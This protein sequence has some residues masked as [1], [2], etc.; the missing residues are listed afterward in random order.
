VASLMDVMWIMVIFIIVIGGLT[1]GLFTPTEAGSV[2]T[3]AILLLSIAK[4]DIDLKRFITSIAESM[5]TACMVL[6]LIT[7]STIMGHFL[8]V[9]EIP[10]LAA[11]WI[12]QLPYPPFLIMIMILLIYEIGGS[13]ID[14]LAFMILAT[15][16]FLPVVVK[17]GYDLIWFGG[18]YSYFL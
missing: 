16:I 6:V 14:D 18:H 9:T 3:F 13:F 5:K 8:A 2:G 7:G 10:L 12:M 17:L 4:K 1:K 15:P 11:D